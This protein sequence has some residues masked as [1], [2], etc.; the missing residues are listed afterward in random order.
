LCG[1][2]IEA[3]HDDAYGLLDEV[4]G[5]ELSRISAVSYCGNRSYSAIE[6]QAIQL[7]LYQRMP[8][9]HRPDEREYRIAERIYGAEMP[10][11]A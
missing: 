3:V 2:E 7:D 6:R 9:G 8:A 5:R 10:A 4:F 1:I 11:S